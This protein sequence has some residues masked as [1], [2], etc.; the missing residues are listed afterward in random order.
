[1]VWIASQNKRAHVFS[2]P[3]FAC[4]PACLSCRPVCHLQVLR[5]RL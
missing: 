1:M 5:E 3:L 2:S 4:L